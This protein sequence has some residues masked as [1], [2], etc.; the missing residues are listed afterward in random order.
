MSA[1]RWSS[2]SRSAAPARVAPHEGA[3]AVTVLGERGF[4]WPE[5]DRWA[6]AIFAASG[7]F[8]ARW[9]GLQE[10]PVISDDGGRERG[11]PPAAET[12]SLARMAR[13]APPRGHG[14]APLHE[15]GV[16]V[17]IV[18]QGEYGLRCT[19]CES[20]NGLKVGRGSVDPPR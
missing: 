1:R 7:T 11:L 3:T 19:V 15:A 9:K 2:S 10:V 16:R 20:L 12:G 8:P 14:A 5:F 17:R 18:Q 4:T 6:K 13:H